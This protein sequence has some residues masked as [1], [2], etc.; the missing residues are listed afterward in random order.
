[1]N[2]D[3]LKLASLFI[4]FLLTMS[5]LVKLYNKEREYIRKEIEYTQLLNESR[6]VMLEIDLEKNKLRQEQLLNERNLRNKILEQEEIIENQREELKELEEFKNILDTVKKFSGRNMGE[7]EERVTALSIYRAS[8][9]TKLD[10]KVI[11]ALI[12]TESSYR[13][14]IVSVDPSY[15]L[16]QLKLPTAN[17]MADKAGA[18]KMTARELL[19]IQNN[20]E[21]GSKYLLSQVIKFSSLSDGIMAYNFGPGRMRQLKREKNKK[22]ESKY[23]KKVKGYHKKIDNFLTEQRVSMNLE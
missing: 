18:K 2:R 15:G 1:M 16:M 10:W 7:R 11:S 22:F 5:L 20:V 21:F 14:N 6:R 17:Y 13:A 8:K 9:E 19:D 3:R 12:M 4:F 23:L